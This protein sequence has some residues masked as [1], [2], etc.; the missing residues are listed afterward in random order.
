MVGV[1]PPWENPFTDVSESDWFYDAVGFVNKNG[2]MV[3][4]DNTTFNPRP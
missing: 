3:G 4:I 1:V 2:L